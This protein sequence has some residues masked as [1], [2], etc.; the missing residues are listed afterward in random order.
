MT[1]ARSRPW[2]PLTRLLGVRVLLD[3]QF[4]FPTWMIFLLE[5]G[6][7]PLQAALIDAIFNG[8]V[9]LAE[10][11]MGAVVDRIGRKR[12]LLISC[13]L[14]TVVFL[15]IGLVSS[16]WLMAL[17]WVL[18]GLLWAL[19]SG[20]DSTYS[21]ELAEEHPQ[22]P[23][24]SRYLGRSRLA[25]GVAGVLSLLSAGFLLEIW[26]PLPYLLTAVLGLLAL[27]L[28]ATLPDVHGHAR[29]ASATTFTDAMQRPRVRTGILLAAIVLTVG[30]SIRIQ[31]QPLG[32]EVGLTP[33]MIGA[34]Y[35]IIAVA[36]ALG[37]WLAT[38]VPHRGHGMW[39]VGSI[40]V[41]ALS[42]LAVALGAQHQLT[43]VTMLLLIPAGT[44][45]FGVAK[46]LTDV[47]LLE[48]VGS[49]WRQTVLALASATNGLVM[50]GF[51]PFLVQIGDTQGNATAFLTW[52]AISGVAAC[53]ALFLVRGPGRKVLDAR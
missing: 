32:T 12:A 48:A 7:T 45:A 44:A 2:G 8:A 51:R 18:W 23:S 47:W 33:S 29:L 38:R 41:M 4:W 46:T 10:V 22:A 24:P 16:F 42:Y 39:I 40:A 6:F 34:V 43:W 1:R 31:F 27:L 28:A 9:V 14:T 3:V 30:V 53:G 25:S 19:S 21:W 36:V 50:I 17:V 35:S 13:A 11:P 49:R 20:L 15:G 5:R 52:A 37:G 26:V